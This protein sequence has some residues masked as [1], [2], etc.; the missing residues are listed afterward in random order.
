MRE[1]FREWHYRRQHNEPAD[2]PWVGTLLRSLLNRIERL[3]MDRVTGKWTNYHAQNSAHE[4]CRSGKDWKKHFEGPRPQQIMA[5][6]G[7]EPKGT[8]LDLGANQGYFSF[9]ASQL[10]FQ[11]TALDTDMGA[12]DRLYSAL[13][14][15]GHRQ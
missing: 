12:I 7:E 3:G 1:I 13:V 15:N 6:L 9:L 5:V 11:A 4:I 2:A 10:G 14:E 8:L